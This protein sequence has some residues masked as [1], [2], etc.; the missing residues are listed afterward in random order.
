[1]DTD[2]Q[3]VID[4]IKSLR[5]LKNA[6]I[7]AHVYTPLEVQEIADFVGDSLGLAQRA[8]L[9]GPTHRVV[10]FCGVRF[11]AE[12]AALLSPERKVLLADPSAGCP[13]ADMVSAEEVRTLRAEHP[14]ATV[15]CYV[16][17]TAA[18]KAE[19]DVCVTSANAVKV[20]RSLPCDEV[21]FVP[22]QN[23]G[24]HVQ[25]RVPEK[26]FVLWP[27]HCPVHRTIR[28]M[29]VEAARSAHPEAV[30]L[31]HPECAPEVLALADFVGS[32]GQIRSFARQ[33]K[34]TAFIIATENGLIDRLAA[35]NPGK[36][37]YPATELSICPNMKKISLRKVRDVLA[38][39]GNVVSVPLD[40]RE[41]AL[42]AVNRML[43]LS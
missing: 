25:S 14:G 40:L 8:A 33:S 24:L 35:D 3:R 17:S 37:F 32:T 28:P 6:V 20:V 10:V 27:G 16:N 13:M 11:M 39:E 1:V 30:V 22:D 9:T 18:V 29:H 42:A 7:L 43:D 41:R 23:L 34:G 19:S 4:E 36:G 38:H 5:R 15:V 21:I 2:R 12:T 26:R 31:A